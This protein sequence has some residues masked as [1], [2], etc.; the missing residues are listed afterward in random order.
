[1]S[2]APTT[3]V[4]H[5]GN[6]PAGLPYFRFTSES[7]HGLARPWMSAMCH[8][9]RSVLDSS[10]ARSSQ[11]SAPIIR[12]AGFAEKVIASV[13]AFCHCS[14]TCMY[15][16]KGLHAAICDAAAA[17]GQ[18][19]AMPRLG[20]DFIF[21]RIADD[22]LGDLISS[23]QAFHHAVDRLDLHFGDTFHL[24]TGRIDDLTRPSS[25]RAAAA[26]LSIIV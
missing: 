6:T 13:H 15:T 9:R 1:M 8:K 21:D 7:G 5:K 16:P 19:P 4:G 18:M 22:E 20:K 14:A 2:G 12:H 11:S 25:A 10:R 26:I 3:A 23:S 17:P 24:R